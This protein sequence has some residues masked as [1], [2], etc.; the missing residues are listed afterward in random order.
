MPGIKANSIQQ[1]NAECYHSTA[2]TLGIKLVASQHNI[3]VRINFSDPWGGKGACDRKGVSVK[4]HKKTFLNSGNIKAAKQ[5]KKAIESDG[6]LNGFR[7]TLCNRD[8]PQ[9]AP[10]LRWEGVIFINN[11]KHRDHGMRV[12]RAQGIGKENFVSRSDFENLEN[13][14]LPHLIVVKDA[15]H[16]KQCLSPTKAR[17]T[18]KRSSAA[19]NQCLQLKESDVEDHESHVDLFPCPEEGGIRSFQVHSSLQSHLDVGRHKYALPGTR[20]V[21]G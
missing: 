19:S 13:F 16:P 6:G 10:K 12:W 7:V 20:N 21:S 1:D 11:V 18:T 8:C 3:T 5:M 9:Q 4:S 2:T 15:L 17:K 14:K